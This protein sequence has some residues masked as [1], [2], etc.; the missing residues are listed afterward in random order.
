MND[1]AKTS[2]VLFSLS[3]MFLALSLAFARHLWEH[4]QPGPPVPLVDPALLAPT[5]IRTSYPQLIRLKADL[6]DFDCYGCHE[7]GK[8]PT[9]R[10]DTNQN[11][12]VPKEHSDVVMGHGRHNRNNNCFNCHDEH[13]LLLLQVR[14]G[15]E[16]KLE[17]SPP[18]CGSCHGPTYRDW[19]AGAHGRTGGYW[20]RAAGE[21]KRQICVDCHNPHSPKIPS[22]TPFPPPHPLRPTQEQARTPHASR[23]L[24]SSFPPPSSSPVLPEFSITRTTPRTSEQAHVTLSPF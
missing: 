8:P 3:L 14:D 20:N 7:K 22:R 5:T 23:L 13:N 6:S 4:P 15:R 11:I 12:I 18:L 16:I 2:A 17:E 21:L 1:Q 9:L 24:S 19:E 10:F